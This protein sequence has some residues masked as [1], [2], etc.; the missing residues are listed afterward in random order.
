MAAKRLSALEIIDE[1]V[2]FYSEDVTR[3][4]LVGHSCE[5]VTRDGRSCAVGRCLTKGGRDGAHEHEGQD[6]AGLSG[7]LDGL[8]LYARYRGHSI[9]FWGLLQDLHDANGN[10][11]A[12]GITTLGMGEADDLREKFGS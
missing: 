6:V 5:Y 9:E 2:A 11:D 4:A 3:R 12:N 7:A 8:P 10:W 1:T